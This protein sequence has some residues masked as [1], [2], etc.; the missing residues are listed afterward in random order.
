MQKTPALRP[1][2]IVS[3]SDNPDALNLVLESICLQ[4]RLPCEVLIAD[5]STD[6]QSTLVAGK[7]SAVLPCPVQ[8][9]QPS[10]DRNS[11]APV[12]NR[13][14]RA[15]TGN[16]LIFIDGDCLLHRRFIADHCRQA[17]P[18]TFVQGRRAG[19]R[20]RFVRRLSPRSFRPLI[21]F[22]QRRSHGLRQGFRR[23]WPSV[24]LN[25]RRSIHGCNF[26][27]WR[28]DC[29]R[30]NGF[31]EAFDESRH[32]MVELAERLFNAGLTLRTITGRAIV[33]HLDHRPVAWYG[34]GVS[35]RILERTRRE[36]IIRCELGLVAPPPSTRTAGSLA[37][38]EVS[39]INAANCEPLILP[40]R[41]RR[42]AA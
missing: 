27:V 9:F 13:A 26:A 3:T 30:A 29:F 24:R 4:T 36:R 23:P 6:N 11:R 22:L 19:V 17:R 38:G 18:G 1:S 33:Y 40:L 37:E 21:W 2:L 20:A 35:A 16:Y 5:Q 34:T 25:D 8:I 10:G 42:N 41:P 32:E 12:L 39:A 15:A 31:N 28:D 7:W 14:V